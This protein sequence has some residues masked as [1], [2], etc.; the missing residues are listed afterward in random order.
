MTDIQ[1]N[2][3][4][5]IGDNVIEALLKILAVSRENNISP[6]ALRTGWWTEKVNYTVALLIK[7]NTPPPKQKIQLTLE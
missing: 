5:Y 1:T 3:I 2:N 6:I 7:L 4:K